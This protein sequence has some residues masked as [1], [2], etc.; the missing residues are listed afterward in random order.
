MSL[1]VVTG[2][3]TGVGKTYLSRALVAALRSVGRV[4][5]LKPIESGYNGAGSDAEAIGAGRDWEAPVY[6]LEE[7][8]APSVAAR[9]AGVDL[10]LERVVSWVQE[11]LEPGAPCLVES[12]GGLFTPLDASGRTNLDLVKLL[13][14]CFWL[15]LAPNRLGVLSEVGAYLRAVKSEHRVPDRV[16]L[17]QLD[18][19][20]SV[21][22]NA[23]EVRRLWPGLDVDELGQ[24]G[25]IPEALL[26]ALVSPR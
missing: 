15:L 20:E 12:A 23:E 1:I 7:P 25:A 4:I 18:S 26:S 14:P 3:G 5:A 21:S 24:A 8:L 19:D 17:N 2:T 10:R 16:V 11:K 22:S 6:A 9:R 13:E